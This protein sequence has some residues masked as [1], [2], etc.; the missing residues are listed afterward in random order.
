MNGETIPQL[1]Q[2]RVEELGDRVALRRKLFGLWKDVSWSEYG[3]KVRETACGL[4]R[5]G[6]ETGDCVAVIGENRPEWL[7][8]D[9]G[10]MAAGGITVGIYTT[11]AAEEVGYI[12]G[13]SRARF[14]IVENEEQL[15]KAL[16]VRE[17]LPDLEKIIVID[18]E[19]LRK[20]KDPMVISFEELLALGRE[21]DGKE[22]DLYRTRLNA[23]EP[24]GV[25]LLIYTSG[26]TGPPKGAMLTHDN[27]IRTTGTLQEVIDV[28]DTD[29]VVSFLPL[30]HIAERMF[31]VFLPLRY[32]F[33]VNFIEN[34]DTVTQNV[35]EVSPTVF[36]AVPRIWEKYYSAI[37]L[38]MQDA[39]LFK[40]L[41]FGLAMRIGTKYAD[42]KLA[43]VPIPRSLS[44][45]FSL[46]H[47]LVFRKLRK[48][49]GFERVRIAV[50]G[51]AP[52]SPD[53]LKFYH[54][55]GIPLR[56]VYGQTEGSG[57]TSM[58][59][60]REIKAGTVG[61]PLPGVQV[62]I[63]DDGEIL[64]KGDNVFRGYFRNPEATAETLVD[65]W[66]H[67]GD[68]GE[69]DE[70]GF[71]KI[72]D[73]KK[74]LIITSGGKNIAPQNIENQLKFSPYINDAVVIGDGR[75]YLAALIIIDED[76]VVKFATDNKIQ[77]T[78][79]ATLTRA[80]EVMKLIRGEVDRVNK[81]LA[82]VE[83]IKKF[84]ILRKKLLEED[85]EVTPTMKVKRKY[86][87]ETFSD[88]IESL[89]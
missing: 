34:T 81:A 63:A 78:T 30:S 39:K 28:R 71:L 58:H 4:M 73:R 32:R 50:S 17:D 9:L 84:A 55:I 67:S 38:R 21:H 36:F 44:A 60:G 14:Y 43:H 75:K 88:L 37:F 66:L 12:L 33:T 2:R 11:N 49:L 6:L 23:S 10:T 42:V 89:Y 8:S 19:G 3:R 46:A 27:I 83:R 74:D 20:F 13:H 86:I 25:A 77:Y 59:R 22:P 87:N 31:S 40:R 15:D 62:K 1:F 7:Y 70:N 18:M 82:R 5:L 41:I 48:R 35:V 54:S 57:P 16:M 72:T 29:E 85:G 79:Y 68:V 45:A 56:E 51:A 26:T 80:P 24:D 64:V 65:G 76:N 53:V 52:I 69:F 47:F 61:P